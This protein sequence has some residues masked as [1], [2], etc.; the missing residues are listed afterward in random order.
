MRAV[1]RY[2]GTIT[3]SIIFLI[4]F[5]EDLSARMASGT[6]FMDLLVRKTA[7]G[8]IRAQINFIPDYIWNG[9]I[10]RLFSWAFYANDLIYFS[11]GILILIFVCAS[12]EK[13]LGSVRMVM[14]YVLLDLS[15]VVA[16][17][18]CDSS[19]K[20]N[21]YFEFGMSG[22]NYMIFALAGSMFTLS[23]TKGNNGKNGDSL[24][25]FSNL[26]VPLYLVL[27]EFILFINMQ[28]VFVY[29]YTFSIGMCIGLLLSIKN[30]NI[31]IFKT[32]GIRREH[33]PIKKLSWKNYPATYILAALCIMFFL[34]NAV[35]V[36]SHLLVEIYGSSSF[37][38][39]AQYILSGTENGYVAQ[40][41][42]MDL[43]NVMQ[44]QVWR[45]VTY[46]F[47]HTGLI[48]LITNVLVLYFAGKYVETKIGTL[49][50]LIVYFASVLSVGLLCILQGTYMSVFSGSS[51]GIYAL[52]TIT[53][54]YSFKSGNR[55]R[56]HFYELIYVAVYFVLA[57]MP[58]IGFCG[59]Y[60]MISFAVGFAAAF[61]FQRR[62]NYGRVSD[63]EHYK[64]AEREDSKGFA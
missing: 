43:G 2:K 38:I 39:W 49:R 57:N 40:W 14:T 18:I 31:Y 50:M 16:A 45:L 64:R 29:I 32:N 63:Q 33:I 11:S 55:D 21:I 6:V 35:L 52:M 25:F 62:S 27:Y 54:L 36:N 34:L 22:I 8:G 60:H 48:H 5:L 58:S 10:W 44:G 46:A 3:I 30:Q 17:F 37:K 26:I 20:N 19:L 1:Y 59:N 13:T 61:I 12:L 4:T 41:M 56:S 23:L 28:N 7:G 15:I 53:L 42:R 9:Q 47:S 24:S 51:L